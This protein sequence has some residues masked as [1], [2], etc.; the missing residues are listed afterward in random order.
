V[1]RSPAALLVVFKSALAPLGLAAALLWLLAG[2]NSGALAGPPSTPVTQMSAEEELAAKYEPLLKLTNQSGACDTGGNVYEPATLG[3][4]F[5]N[6]EV[7]L[8][9]WPERELIMTAPEAADLMG[10]G[11]EYY[12][13][14]P[15]I[16]VDPMPLRTD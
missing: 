10:L 8:R 1:K 7:E 2:P 3:I 14:S 13:T 6:P 5:G 9:R 15:A 4:L 11:E 16:R 12:S